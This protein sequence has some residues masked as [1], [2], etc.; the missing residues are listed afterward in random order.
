MNPYGPCYHT[1]YV[2]CAPCVHSAWDEGYE[3]ALERVES[4]AE[5]VE[6]ILK[7]TIL[8]IVWSLYNEL[9]GSHGSHGSHG[10]GEGEA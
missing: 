7:S 3:I 8:D 9:H 2:G 5:T 1:K 4:A 10:E 6:P